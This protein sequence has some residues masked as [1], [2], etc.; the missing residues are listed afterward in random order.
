MRCTF[1]PCANPTCPNY[2]NAECRPNYCGEECTEEY[3]D[4][5]VKVDCGVQAE[6]VYFLTSFFLSHFLSIMHLI[7]LT[8]S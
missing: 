8:M 3:Y 5:D 4:G 2:P 7:E 1:S 6:G